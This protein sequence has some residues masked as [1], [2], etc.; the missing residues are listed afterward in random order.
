MINAYIYLA[1]S[2]SLF[3]TPRADLDEIELPPGFH[4]VILQ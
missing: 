4:V 3:F 2:G 1:S